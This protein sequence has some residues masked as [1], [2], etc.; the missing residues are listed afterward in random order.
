MDHCGKELRYFNWSKGTAD[1]TADLPVNDYQV[2]RWG[3]WVETT[4]GWGSCPEIGLVGLVEFVDTSFIVLRTSKFWVL[5][6]LIEC[7]GSFYY[8]GYAS[9]TT[10]HWITLQ[11]FIFSQRSSCGGVMWFHLR[12]SETSRM[13]ICF[14]RNCRLVKSDGLPGAFCLQWFLWRA[15]SVL[16]RCRSKIKNQHNGSLPQIGFS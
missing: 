3:K 12:R 1:R 15:P 16:P 7:L 5:G 11:Y 14:A 8:K 9:Q 13:Y 10:V 2:R 6:F 4:W